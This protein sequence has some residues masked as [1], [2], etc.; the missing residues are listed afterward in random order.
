MSQAQE[1][2]PIATPGVQTPFCGDL[3]SKKYFTLAVLPS[4][5]DDYLDASGYCWCFHTEGVLGPDGGHAH[6]ELCIPG[7]SCYRSALSEPN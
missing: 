4:E 5:P 7:R 3:R 2:Q 6:P 1:P